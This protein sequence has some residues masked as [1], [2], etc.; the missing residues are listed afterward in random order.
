MTLL[1]NI[2]VDRKLIITFR[3]L[4]V[5]Y[6]GFTQL[7]SLL[8]ATQLIQFDFSYFRV[9]TTKLKLTESFYPDRIKLFYLKQTIFFCLTF[10]TRAT[11]LENNSFY[12]VCVLQI[13]HQLVVFRFVMYIIQCRFFKY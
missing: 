5:N 13:N 11:L 7:I 3:L 8:Y 2:R 9:V 4:V 10:F 1:S 12:E 6:V